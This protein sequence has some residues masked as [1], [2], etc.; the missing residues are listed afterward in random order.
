[1]LSA[2][3]ILFNKLQ[4]HKI[5]TDSCSETTSQLLGAFSH[6][7][8]KYQGLFFTIVPHFLSTFMTMTKV[9][10]EVQRTST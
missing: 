9:L 7:L 10:T 2:E 3:Q 4:Q 1:M 5:T 6:C 8:S